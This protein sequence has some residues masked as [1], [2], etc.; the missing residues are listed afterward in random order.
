MGVWQWKCKAGLSWDEVTDLAAGRPRLAGGILEKSSFVL[1]LTE[2]SGVAWISVCG[3][4]IDTQMTGL[5]WALGF[6]QS[7]STACG[8]EEGMVRVAFEGPREAV[9][10]PGMVLR[11]T[12]SN[13]D[14]CVPFVFDAL[15]VAASALA[16][17]A[18][19]LWNHIS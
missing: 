7:F 10:V 11:W 1:T 2:D 19:G 4:G 12:R 15:L 17:R 14:C 3:E 13:L 18:M 9:C 5:S 16:I 6:I 8:G